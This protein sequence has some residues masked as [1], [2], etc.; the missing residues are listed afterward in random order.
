V[1]ILLQLQLWTI[2]PHHLII[3]LIKWA[4]CGNWK[5]GVQA[6]YGVQVAGLEWADEGVG[7]WCLKSKDGE[8]LGKFNAVVVADKGAAKLLFGQT[9]LGENFLP[10]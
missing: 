5:S 4:E 2:F 8:N 10:C 6:K 9:P 3:V 7:T 1:F